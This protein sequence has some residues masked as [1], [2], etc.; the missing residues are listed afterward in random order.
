MSVQ[1][2]SIAP[3]MCR[4]PDCQTAGGCVGVCS[5]PFKWGVDYGK[6]IL[7]DLNQLAHASGTGALFRDVM[8]R[9]F[10]EITRLRKRA[11][12]DMLTL[13]KEIDATWP[14]AT[15]ELRERTRKVIAEADGQPT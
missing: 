6:N 12:P 3:E 4:Y 15:S 5:R 13:L 7:V 11:A 14:V 10:S 1:A 8:T 9:A 2:T